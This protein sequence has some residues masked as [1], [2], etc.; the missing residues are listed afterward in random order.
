MAAQLRLNYDIKLSAALGSG[1]FRVAN[2]HDAGRQSMP[3][4]STRNW[5]SLT[6]W[7]RPGRAKAA[8]RAALAAASAALSAVAVCGVA[9]AAQPAGATAV[10]THATASCR[11]KTGFRESRTNSGSGSWPGHFCGTGYRH[12]WHHGQVWEH[13]QRVWDAT[14]PYHRLWFHENGQTWC[15]WGPSHKVVPKAFKVPGN[16]LISQNTSPC[17]RQ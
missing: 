1:G 5:S 6:G 13:F 17:P 3:E 12:P 14:S 8:R 16:I 2:G 11:P 10:R 15:A 4:T 9:V 7:I